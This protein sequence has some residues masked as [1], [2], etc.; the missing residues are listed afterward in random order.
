MRA[1]FFLQHSCTC[2][3]L[4]TYC[5]RL[6]TSNLL[7]MNFLQILLHQDE[8]SA[9]EQ[10]ERYSVPYLIISSQELHEQGKT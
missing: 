6:T 1:E 7:L 5:N 9:V 2:V 3:P 8:N 10:E 4:Y